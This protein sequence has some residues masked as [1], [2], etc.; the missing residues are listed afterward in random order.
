M[1]WPSSFIGNGLLK[2]LTH[3]VT[4]YKPLRESDG[5]RQAIYRDD[6]ETELARLKRNRSCLR[7]VALERTLLPESATFHILCLS[8]FGDLSHDHGD[9]CWSVRE[10]AQQLFLLIAG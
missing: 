1:A 7:S 3:F 2:S 9:P 6:S 4:H 8:R 5:M 10:V